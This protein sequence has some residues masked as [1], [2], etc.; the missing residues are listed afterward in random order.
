MFSS[1]ASTHVIDIIMLS[2]NR[3]VSSSECVNVCSYVIVE[4]CEI[5][6]L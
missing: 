1:V 5:L 2:D 4:V 6:T 3:H